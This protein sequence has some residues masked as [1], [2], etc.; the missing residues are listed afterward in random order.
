MS[1][2]ERMK[3]NYWTTTMKSC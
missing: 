1:Y 2:C 3:K